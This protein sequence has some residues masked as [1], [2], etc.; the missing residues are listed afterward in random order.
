[1]INYEIKEKYNDLNRA[2]KIYDKVSDK[3]G[4]YVSRYLKKIRS[5]IRNN[6]NL[7]SSWY[8]AE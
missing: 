3:M 5:E 6:A 4:V 8:F 7:I 1:M 2:V